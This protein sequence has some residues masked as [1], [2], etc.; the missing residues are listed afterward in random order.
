[1]GGVSKKRARQHLNR[2]EKDRDHKQ[3][4]LTFDVARKEL[5]DLVQE[6]CVKV[7]W[8]KKVY[9]CAIE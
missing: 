9:T 5:Y 6:Q 3:S 4:M 2:M 1:M 7:Q 8:E